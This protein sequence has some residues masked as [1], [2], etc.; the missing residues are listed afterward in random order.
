MGLQDFNPPDPILG[1]SVLEHIVWADLEMTG[2]DVR[3]DVILEAAVLVTDTTLNV[4]GEG[5]DV[6]VHATEGELSRMK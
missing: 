6:V 5:V 1:G 4:L 3:H 2:L